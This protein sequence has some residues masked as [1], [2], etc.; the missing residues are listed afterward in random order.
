MKRYSA[1]EK[2][3]NNIATKDISSNFNISFSNISFHLL[4]CEGKINDVDINKFSPP[5]KLLIINLCR[6][7]DS[8]NIL[9]NSF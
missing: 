7:I 3:K 2:N 4:L 1:L 6:I 8:S 5:S 9:S